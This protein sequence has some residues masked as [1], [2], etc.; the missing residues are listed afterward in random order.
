LNG[1]PESDDESTQYKLRKHSLRHGTRVAPYYSRLLKLKDDL[2]IEGDDD[3]TPRRNSKIMNLDKYNGSVV[4]ERKS[5]NDFREDLEGA[6]KATSFRKLDIPV[7]EFEERFE[8][9]PKPKNVTEDS[10]NST[11]NPKDVSIA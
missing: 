10:S 1:S 8:P 11:Q 5:K 3:K 9:K 2:N 7:H 4:L 6:H